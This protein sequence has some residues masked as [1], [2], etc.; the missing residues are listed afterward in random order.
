MAN[1]NDYNWTD[2]ATGK[3]TASGVGN[4]TLKEAP[5]PTPT[6]PTNQ[7]AIPG[8]E[9]NTAEKQNEAFTNIQ[10]VGNTLYGT[11][12]APILPDVI[13]QTDFDSSM[14]AEKLSGLNQEAQGLTKFTPDQTKGLDTLSA[15]IATGYAPT[16]TDIKNLDY[17]KSKGY[18]YSPTT[19]IISVTGKPEPNKSTT[20]QIFEAKSNLAT[21]KANARVEAAKTMGL[22]EKSTAIAVAQTVVNQLRTDLQNQGI[23][24]IKEQDVIRAKPIL[25]AQIAGQ[26]SELSREQKLDAMI[27]QNNY[28]NALVESQIAQG[29][30]DRAREVVTEIA[31]DAYQASKDQIDALLFKGEIEQIAADKLTKQLEDE[32]DLALDGYIH[33]KSPEALKGLT[34]DKIYRDPVNGNVYLKPEPEVDKV[35]EINGVSYGFDK[36]GNKIA[37]Y[38]TTATPKGRSS[39][40]DEEDEEDEEMS[41]FDLASAHVNDPDNAHFTPEQLKVQLLAEVNAGNIDLSISEINSIIDARESSAKVIEE[42]SKPKTFTKD[43]WD[44]RIKASRDTGVSVDDIAT[45]MIETYDEDEINKLLKEQGFKRFFRGKEGELKLYINSILE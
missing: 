8:A 14:S 19:E 29:N 28:N 39:E 38:G 35:L 24:D 43:W 12:K 33:I 40:E 6:P 34:E 21:I 26:L 42:E 25:T 15:K 23:M 44:T 45:K 5:T 16:E 3:A 2:P 20:D 1:K 10:P 17:A 7:V 30:Y 41:D 32:R 18:V 9:F 13:S 31:D 37:T 22:D 11:P 4:P 36:Q 27:L